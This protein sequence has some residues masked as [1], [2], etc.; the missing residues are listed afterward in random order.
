M[1]RRIALLLILSAATALAEDGLVAH[2]KFDE[3]SGEIASDSSGG[4]H[5]GT[6]HHAQR[7]AGAGKAGGALW[8][9]GE[10]A[11]VD[12]GAA[13]TLNLGK[14]FTI[15]AWIKP[16]APNGHNMTILAKGFRYAGCFN[17]RMGIPWDRSKLMLE[18]GAYRT[19]EIPIPLGEWSQVAGVCDGQ[20][21]GIFV[22][23][24]LVSSR[25]FG[26]GFKPNETSLTIG[27]SVGAPDGGEFFKGLI[28]EV[29]IYNRALPKY[30]LSGTTG[31]EIHRG[32]RTI[33]SEGP[34][35]GYEGFPSVVLLKNQQLLVSFYAGRGHMDWPDPAL[36]KRGRICV[37][38]SDD[39]GKTW[40]EPR[41]IIDTVVG[42]RDPSLTQLSDGTVICSYFQTVWYE[43]GR[44]CEVRTIRSFDNGLTWETRPAS[45]PA[46]WFSEAEKAEVIRQASPE[47]KDASHEH[48]VKEEF[49]ALNATS[50]PVTQLSNGE[51]LLPI[52]GSHNGRPWRC[53]MARSTD[54]GKSWSE[55]H[56]IPGSDHLTEPDIVEL[57]GGRLLCIM[58]TEMAHSFSN[59][60]GRTWTKPETGVLPRGAA[61]DLLMTRDGVLLC[62]HREQPSPRTG[63]IIS[64]D[65]GKTWSPPRM[66]DFCGGAYPSFAELPDGRIFGV[67][68]E[69]GLG[70]NVRQAIFTVDRATRTIRL[71]PM[72]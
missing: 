40:S 28:D 39:L 6:I 37:M 41:T 72:R 29:R 31:A 65:F 44:V 25:P 63:V 8:C 35:G 70:G 21:V 10:K 3:D 19:H 22:N 68:Y 58:R 16:E 27:K 47:S 34:W 11:F 51:L 38:S 7:R 13:E 33:T 32:N 49:A 30:V 12:F 54:S 48:P 45:V 46:P 66:I 53:A 18:A 64:T 24:E 17:L 50:V 15:E 36:P 62:G 56:E 55:I 59:D 69:E 42:E 71:D 9:D 2:W 20:R 14:E 1:M 26:G 67:H 61:P 57:P 5:D 52:Y 4:G 43:R 23:G 60:L